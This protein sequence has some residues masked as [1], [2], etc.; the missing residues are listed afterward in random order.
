VTKVAWEVVVAR[1]KEGNEEL[2]RMLSSRGI[3]AAA[4]ETIR[5]EDPEGWNLVD[6]AIDRISSF[7]WVAFT[8]PRGVAAFAGRLKALGI[9]AEGLGP[10]FAAVG[11]KTAAALRGTGVE[12]HYIPPEFLT[13]ALGEGLPGEAGSRVL[14][15]RADIGDKGLVASL[16][17]RGFEVD[18]VV[19]YRTR[20]VPGRV[21][22]DIVRSTR[23]VAFASPSEVEGFCRRIDGAE[24]G[25]LA[26]RAT[27]VCIGPVT[28]RAA[29]RAGFRKISHAKVHTLEALVDKIGELMVHA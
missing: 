18:D 27:A 4:V 1:S 9:R 26:A 20:L 21:E 28:A 29:E 7:D 8:S 5:L 12:V 11:T 24:F 15:L 22:P 3:G 10:K 16:V 14:L 25:D 2:Q 6:Q 17:R 19:A 23:I 13:S